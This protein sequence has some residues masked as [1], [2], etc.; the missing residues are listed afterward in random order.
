LW[1]QSLAQDPRNAVACLNLALTPGVA[2]DPAQLKS[3]LEQ[4][5][6]W[7]RYPQHALRAHGALAS[8]AWQDE[9]REAALRHAQEALV[10]ARALP[11]GEVA[12]H[13]RVRRALL[14]AVMAQA[15]GETARA[16][17][18]AADALALA[19]EHAAVLAYRASVLLRG[20]V[21]EGKLA[22]DADAARVQAT[23]L[24]DRAVAA[25]P[26]AP[27][28]YVVRGQWH[29]AAGA[30]LAAVKCFDDALVRAP[31]HRDAHASKVDLLLAQGLFA[32]AEAAARRAIALHVDD[33][34]MLSKLGMALFGQR[35]LADARS[36]YE[37][38]LR[39]RPRDTSV[40]RLLAGV[41]VLE[42][43][44]L[45]FQLPGEQL[46]ARAERIMDLEPDHAEAALFLAVARRHQRKLRDALV[47]LEGAR[48]RLPHDD[49]VERLLAETHRD[50]GYQLLLAG[51]ERDRGIDHLHQ[52]CQLAPRELDTAAARMVIEQEVTRQENAGV[53]AFGKEEF[54]Q[55]EAHFRRC[56]A[57]QPDR[58]Y[59]RYQ[60]GL[61]LLQRGGE[62]SQQALALLRSAEEGLR[63]QGH[64]ASR[65][66]LYQI[67][68]LRRLG[69]TQAAQEKA[70]AFVAA[71]ENETSAAFERIR[72]LAK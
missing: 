7:A 66:V 51:A 47:L 45:L 2:G 58:A 13:E 69:E 36:F 21:V 59:T 42:T 35:K 19:P 71:A 57:L 54:A 41:L 27:D 22:S 4:A 60:L 38:A 34:H 46:Q 72:E 67:I 63:A 68:A 8:A 32:P 43:R 37:D 9:R 55:A 18:F 11:D 25:D 30:N 15:C 28:P 12:R 6:T 1:R 24:L 17:E 31:T 50:L 52:F 56:L 23:E 70:R 65:A 44:P 3:L 61:T 10:A 48:P 20:A 49:D 26:A 53:A 39:L 64:D 5:A 40:R 14:G 29:A 62:G 33:A 16:D